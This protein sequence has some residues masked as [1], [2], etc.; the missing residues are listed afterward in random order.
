MDRRASEM[1]QDKNHPEL[2]DYA[3]NGIGN[4]IR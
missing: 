3:E 4:Y 1:K 2:I